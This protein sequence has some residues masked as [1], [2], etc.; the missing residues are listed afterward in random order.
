MDVVSNT[1]WVGF[2]CMWPTFLVEECRGFVWMLDLRTDL[3]TIS[4]N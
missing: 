2:W 4:S 1:S 3:D